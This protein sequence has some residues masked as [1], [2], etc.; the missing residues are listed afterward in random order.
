MKT[1]YIT[2]FSTIAMA[3]IAYSLFYAG[4]NAANGDHEKMGLDIIFGLGWFVF[5]LL[6]RFDLHANRQKELFEHIEK[7]EKQLEDVDG[8]SEANIDILVGIAAE[9]YPGVN[10]TVE[11][12]PNL[13]TEYH[14]R[15]GKYVHCEMV[16]GGVR[17]EF[18]DDP[19]I[20]DEI[21]KTTFDAPKPPVK[22]AVVSLNKK[23][24]KSKSNQA[25][26]DKH[27]ADRR[28]ARLTKKKSNNGEGA[29]TTTKG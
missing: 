22:V 9:L 8:Q 25:K 28:A 15:T 23:P 27:N 26:R 16:D 21:E 17:T 19:F 7:L 1:R 6:L 11:L 24:R 4:V 5:L 10:P 29:A 13:I 18:S 14:A 20:D 12:L 2:L 3:A